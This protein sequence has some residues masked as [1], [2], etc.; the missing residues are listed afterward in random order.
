MIRCFG[1]CAV[2]G[3]GRFMIDEVECLHL[4]TLHSLNSV[5]RRH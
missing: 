2:M 3:R 1:G 5:D 4:T